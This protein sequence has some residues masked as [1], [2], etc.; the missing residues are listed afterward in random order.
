MHALASSPWIIAS[1]GLSL[2]LLSAGEAAAQKPRR[3]T[4]EV[5][6]EVKRELL[7]KW[8]GWNE[9]FNN[10]WF[11]IPTWQNPL[12]VWVTQEIFQEVKPD[13]VIEA[14]TNFGGSAVLWSA[15]LEHIHPSG[16]VI[17]IDIENRAQEA[18]AH[19]LAKERVQ[20]IVASSTAPETLAQ[21][22]PVVE[23]KK[24]LLILDSLHTREHVFEELKLYSGF[25]P[26]GSYII[27]QD[28][29][30]TG[31]GEAVQDFVAI[32]DDFEIDL[33]RNRYLLSNN[34]NGFLKRVR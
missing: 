34:L 11:G 28:T 20:F 7:E 2:S 26:R 23:G 22:A 27:V 5:S 4:E 21:I 3:Q 24:V 6:Q 17:T 19:P 13:I 10:T 18:R 8:P 14:G 12:D 32:S 25:V 1:L 15:L 16:R 9:H 30:G 31:A 29:L 33:S